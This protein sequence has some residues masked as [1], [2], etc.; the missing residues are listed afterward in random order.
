MVSALPCG[1]WAPLSS[2]VPKRMHA[3]AHARP[4]PCGR[5]REGAY[6]ED[7]MLRLGREAGEQ[8]KAEA[9]P[10]FFDW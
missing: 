5:P 2:G 1:A 4:W 9:G 6:N 3:C 10:D 7:D 8:L